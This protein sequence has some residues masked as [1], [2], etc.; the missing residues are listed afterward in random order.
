MHPSDSRT[1]VL[2]TCK[3][4]VIPALCLCDNVRMFYICH[5]C[6]EARARFSGFFL[7][8]KLKSACHDDAGELPAIVNTKMAPSCSSRLAA[9]GH[10]FSY[11]IRICD[12]QPL[13]VLLATPPGFCSTLQLRTKHAHYDPHSVLHDYRHA[14]GYICTSWRPSP[15]SSVWS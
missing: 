2:P 8:F 13:S 3:E 9:D 5:A 6:Y 11:D 4:S 15:I 12:Q 14:H 7:N 1:C 10:N